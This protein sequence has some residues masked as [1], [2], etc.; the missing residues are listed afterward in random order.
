VESLIA[1]VQGG[2]NCTGLIYDLVEAAE[3]EFSMPS[4]SFLVTEQPEETKQQVS[5]VEQRGVVLADIG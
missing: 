1:R 2:S 3:P 5:S 4:R